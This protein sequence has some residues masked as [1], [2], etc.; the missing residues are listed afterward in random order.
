MM[1]IKYEARRVDFDY[2]R[3]YGYRVYPTGY[4]MYSLFYA[5]SGTDTRLESARIMREYIQIILE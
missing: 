5:D 1:I 3:T 4:K 2:A